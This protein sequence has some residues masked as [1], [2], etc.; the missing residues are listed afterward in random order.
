M[1]ATRT[2]LV[3]A[4]ALLGGLLAAVVAPGSGPASADAVD[5]G[6][7][8]SATGSITETGSS[9]I[10]G[11]MAQQITGAP[12]EVTVPVQATA[13][14]QIN[15]GGVIAT[16]M[17]AVVDLSTLAEDILQSR[18]KPGITAAGYPQLAGSA[19]VTIDL[20][21]TTLSYALPPGTA[22]SGT[23]TGWADSGTGPIS[24][25]AQ[26]MAGRPSV[27]LGRISADTRSPGPAASGSLS[28]LEID[29]GGAAPRSVDLGPPTLTFTAAVGV[30]VLFNGVS[31]VGG[32]T[33]G[34]DC[35]PVVAVDVA[36]TEV[37]SAPVSS[38][39]S[40]S[41][42]SVV[43]P[44]T[45]PASS[46][47]STTWPSEIRTPPGSCRVSG[48]D[49]YDGFSGVGLAATG[50]FRTTRFGGRW[51]LVTPDGHPFF[52]QGINHITFDGTPDRN[53]NAVYRDTVAAKYGSPGAWG[54]AQ[55]ERM[56]A[57]GYNTAGAWS[58]VGV[59]AGRKPYTILLSLTGS[60]FSTG[61]MTDLFAPAW[62]D[63]VRSSVRSAAAAHRDDPYLVGYWL[64]NELHWGPDWRPLHLFD[65]YLDR[66]AAAPG[67]QALLA[68][69]EARYAT[70]ED[71]A[72][73][74]TTTAT[75]WASLAA[76]SSVTAWTPGGGEATRAAWVGA[77]AEHY[78]SVT[79]VELRRADPNHLNLGPRLIAQTAGVPVLEAAARHVDVVSFN[80]YTILP[81][82]V[83]PLL[84]ADPTYRPVDGPLAAQAQLLDKPLLISEWSYRAA[85]SGLPNTWP[86]LFP[87]L[88]TQAQRASAYESYVRALLETPYV[89]GQHWFEHADEPPAG[90]GDGEDSNFGLVTLHDD[91]YPELV[92][93]SRTMH[94]CA[95]ARLLSNGGGGSTTTSSWSPSPS[96]SASPSGS[97]TRS[98]PP[99]GGIRSAG[100][101]PARPVSATPRFTA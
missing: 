74:F 23:P 88:R 67:K 70:F 93:I 84:R 99:S 46:T 90:R 101:V 87:T 78:F 34:W 45:A 100:S 16:T 97:A 32:V 56:S 26:W 96:S 47:T 37:V 29:G 1:L 68:F 55:L 82:L 41:S 52:S 44:T 64:D 86:P 4:L 57:W 59:F 73:D 69:L 2:R 58:D 18:V 98:R 6:E 61:R 91:P 9:L 80:L 38:A 22:P 14:S 17:T 25:Q 54:D 40:S 76:P 94:D 8:C 48:F 85:D 30:G 81:E 19:F 13:T 65:D 92:A 21:A 77:V 60:D 51:W 7:R 10:S 71:F 35:E 39:S 11:P 83:G 36:R 3:V 53:G 50:F 27:T 62:A 33:N 31:I 15:P 89:V 43:V 42:S 49:D 28:W 72:A 66:P 63:R 12:L 95:Y 20:D 5:V 79:S 24:A 75:D